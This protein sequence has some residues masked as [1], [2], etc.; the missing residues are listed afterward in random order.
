[1]QKL[2]ILLPEAPG[3]LATFARTTLILVVFISLAACLYY[4]DWNAK[5]AGFLSDDAVYLLMSDGFSPFRSDDSELI[6]YVFRQSLFPPL[7]P[8]LL[9][10]LGAGSDS[11]LWAHVVTTTTLVSA[12]AVFGLWV[13][14][15][16]R[17][18]FAAIGLMVLFALLP[19]TL[20]LSLDLLSEFPYLLLS[21]L[22]LWLATRETET[23]RGYLWIA[24]FVG[25][26]AT[27][28]S[29]GLSLI[30]A[31]AIWL[32]PQRVPKRTKWLSLFV[33]ICPGLLWS[34]YKSVFIGSR[35][36]Y[37]QFWGWLLSQFRDNPLSEFVPQFLRAQGGGLWH[38][39]I[40]ILDL[41]AGV[42]TQVALSTLLMAALP[43]WIQRLKSWRLDAWYFLV[44]GAML[45]L[46]PFP[47]FF[48]RLLLPWLPILLLYAYLGVRS[49]AD[50][51]ASVL[52]KPVLA[53]AAL[54]AFFLTLLPSLGFLVY[55]LNEPIDSKLANW[56]H[57]RYWFRNDSMEKILSD[58]QF[59]QN[60]IQASQDIGQF[61]PMGK[62][63]YGVHTAI[64]MLYG[65]RIFEQP[66]PPSASPSSFE[67]RSQACEFFFLAA[68]PGVIGADPAPAFYPN[69]RLSVDKVEI[70]HVWNDD[71]HLNTATAI[72]AR[73][74]PSN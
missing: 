13:F 61:V 29:A 35:G 65:R 57:T 36:G 14:L 43:T 15:E 24:V 3:N 30:L 25:L 42:I 21:L 12:L 9:A 34:V 74:K 23:R 28:R 41:R 55:R 64:A 69:D 59:R 22:A 2:K 16:T 39:L 71:S 67:E 49:V 37:N 56:K 17:D 1:M 60:L 58:V 32:I 48:S 45:F 47:D 66:A 31:M 53:Y 4:L 8:L 6:Q 73:R 11:L 54:A 27:T 46:Y 33:A 10:V 52:G 63:V 7:Y 72:L 50:S 20:I 18:R 62:C 38:G 5:S 44:G 19:G 51:W 26:A 68:A 40:A 70:V